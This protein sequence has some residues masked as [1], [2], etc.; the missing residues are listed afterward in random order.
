MKHGRPDYDRIQDPSGLI[1][2][3]EPVF[4]LRGQDAF[5]AQCVR[6]WANAV[7]RHFEG[8]GDYTEVERQM[9][10][11]ARYQAARM[12]LYC[13]ARAGARL[14]NLPFPV[15]QLPLPDAQLQ[16]LLIDTRSAAMDEIKAMTGIH[17]ATLSLPG[18]ASMDTG[19][20]AMTDEEVEQALAADETKQAYEDAP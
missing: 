2:D 10:K 1:P 5:A 20:M 9:V 14:P 8:V 7:E 6:D 16:Q 3:D 13:E 12:D 15:L 19:V 17:D 4:L 18:S 11:D